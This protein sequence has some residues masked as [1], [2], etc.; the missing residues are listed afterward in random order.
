MKIVQS[1][2]E[3]KH[4][5]VSCVT[6]GTFDGVHLGHQ[7]LIRALT[8]KAKQA[9]GRSVLLTFEPHPQ[10]LLN[11]REAIR[12]TLADEKAAL[13]KT[14]DIDLLFVVPFTQNLADLAPEDFIRHYLIE[15]VGLSCLVAGFNHAFGKNKQGTRDFLV[16]LSETHDFK[17]DIVDPVYQKGLLISSS[18]IRDLMQEGDVGK[19]SEMLGRP[20]TVSGRVIQGRRIGGRLGFPTANV[21]IADPQKMIP[22]DGVYAVRTELPGSRKTIPSTCNIGFA[23]TLKNE[24]REIE[25]YLHDYSGD[26]YGNSVTIQFIERLRDEKKFNSVEELVRQINQDRLHTDRLLSQFS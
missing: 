20:Y 18:K 22:A 3:I 26:L 19:A 11:G 9:G 7:A 10:T 8:N 14:M 24:K 23:P 25:I 15:G 21:R 1:L 4:D 16:R 2:D 17:L 13:L 12:L 5:P 6:I